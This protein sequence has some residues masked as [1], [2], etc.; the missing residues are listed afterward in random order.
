MSTKNAKNIAITLPYE[1]FIIYSLDYQHLSDDFW[2]FTFDNVIISFKKD[3]FHLKSDKRINLKNTT[4][5]S[6]LIGIP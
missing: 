4:I 5:F 1:I 3:D 6:F 2:F